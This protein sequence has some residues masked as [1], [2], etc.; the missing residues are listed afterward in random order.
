MAQSLKG[1][2]EGD[3][4]GTE[5]ELSPFRVDHDDEIPVGVQLDWRLRSL[6]TS[7][8]L[9]S[10]DRLPSVRALAEWAGVNVNT[11]RSVYAGLERR[12]IV[13]SHHGAGT[14]VASEGSSSEL[15]RIAASAIAEARAV[16]ASARDLAM[17][18]FACSGIADRDGSDSAPPGMASD[19]PA[20]DERSMRAEL[21][22]QIGYLEA[23][24]ASH[25]RALPAPTGQPRPALARVAETEQ[26]ERTR[27]EL[28]ARLA[29]ARE[30][31]T[32]RGT[33]EQRARQVRE[34]MLVDPGS[35]RWESVSDSEMGEAGCRD[36]SV[37]AGPL[38]SL[39]SW[40][41]V[42]V[43]GGCPLSAPA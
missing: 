26:L 36:Y 22:R 5:T 1:S 33:R 38:G 10:G 16:G 41:R 42:K 28:L 25:A 15:E 30:A 29:E 7:G 11:V 19:A 13:A 6:I 4:A 8:R 31:E 32:R 37:S 24:L 39:M 9:A 17:L 34:E 20:I 21:R 2:N 43:S 27:D 35:H 18:T 23:Q 40:W 12:G 14:F 3:R